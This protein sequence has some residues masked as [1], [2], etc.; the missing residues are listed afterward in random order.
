M[1]SNLLLFDEDSFEFKKYANYY[2]K[3][4]E[5]FNLSTV[6]FS[7]TTV[8][9]DFEG[10]SQKITKYLDR[11]TVVVMSAKANDNVLNNILNIISNYYGTRI[12]THNSIKYCNS[13]MGVCV[14]IDNLE[15]FAND[16]DVEFFVN[17]LSLG[18]L[19]T[20]MQLFGLEKNEVKQLYYEVPNATSFDISVYCK[21]KISQVSIASKQN[22]PKD[23]ID[24]FLRNVHLQFQNY[25]FADTQDSI[26]DKLCCG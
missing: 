4:Q 10:I 6:E 5:I 1:K 11:M 25:W 23:Y 9:S 21:D 26:L 17:E 7:N 2:V 8:F 12:N 3:L 19:C 20:F 15:E 24:E 13:Q 18:K 22:Y 16:W 14:I